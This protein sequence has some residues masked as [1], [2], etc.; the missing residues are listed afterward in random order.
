VAEAEKVVG[1]EH[2][3]ELSWSCESRDDELYWK[4]GS[5]VHLGRRGMDRR[6][7]FGSLKSEGA[8]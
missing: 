7:R 1:W 6:G 8:T 2:V 3:S 5:S 4:G